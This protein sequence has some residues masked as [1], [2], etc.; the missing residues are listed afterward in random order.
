MLD[1]YYYPTKDGKNIGGIYMGKTTNKF[2]QWG[3]MSNGRFWK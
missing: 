2:Y 1:W 3:D